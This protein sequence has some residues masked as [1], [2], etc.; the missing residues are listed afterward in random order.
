MRGDAV[1]TDVGQTPSTG[2]LSSS[3]GQE[4]GYDGGLHQPQHSE[5]R[6]ERDR[7]PTVEQGVPLSGCG[8]DVVVQEC[9]LVKNNPTLRLSILFSVLAS[10]SY[11][12]EVSYKGS[13]VSYRFLP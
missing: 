1:Y 10:N 4:V 13:F 3:V 6:V 12:L 8:R 5:A 9:C 2:R 7:G 11:F